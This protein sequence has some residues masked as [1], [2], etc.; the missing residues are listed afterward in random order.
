MEIVLAPIDL[1]GECNQSLFPIQVPGRPMSHYV[2]K[3]D[4]EKRVRL[5]NI[6]FQ[7]K[8]V[9]ILNNI[10]ETTNEITDEFLSPTNQL[11]FF[12]S[13]FCRYIPKEWRIEVLKDP[14][15]HTYAPVSADL[16]G[17]TTRICNH[18]CKCGCY[19]AQKAKVNIVANLICIQCSLLRTIIDLRDQ[20]DFCWIRNDEVH[21]RKHQEY[22]YSSDNSWNIMCDWEKNPNSILPRYDPPRWNPIEELNNT[23]DDHVDKY[24]SV[25]IQTYEWKD[26]VLMIPGSPGSYDDRNIGLERE[27]FRQIIWP[28]LTNPRIKFN[29]LFGCIASFRYPTDVI[30]TFIDHPMGHDIVSRKK[31]FSFVSKSGEPTVGGK[32]MAPQCICVCG[33]DLDKS[34]GGYQLLRALHFCVQCTFLRGLT[35]L[36][37]PNS[38]GPHVVNI[39]IDRS[40]VRDAFTNEVIYSSDPNNHFYRHEEHTSILRNDPFYFGLFT[41]FPNQRLTVWSNPPFPW[42]VLE[43]RKRVKDE[44]FIDNDDEEMDNGD[45][46]NS[47]SE[48]VKSSSVSSNTSSHT[49]DSRPKKLQ[50]N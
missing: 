11:L 29:P 31:Y 20:P 10:G 12:G 5:E 48:A 24:T 15:G 25:D 9:P 16:F 40:K 26:Q 1:Y 33:C 37:G 27:V 28:T 6:F 38:V 4:K 43:D 44:S 34:K 32:C 47:S 8:I 18:Q 7:Q 2:K 21:K 13:L 14:F 35:D 46:G 22:C 17:R 3:E 42:N 45:F 39:R 36:F 23:Q 50:K 49:L 41:S 30:N 19:K